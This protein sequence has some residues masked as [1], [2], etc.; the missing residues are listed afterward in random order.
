MKVLLTGGT[1][2]VGSHATKSLIRAG[3]E[4][5]LLVRD[6]KKI[7]R[8]FKPHGVRPSDY[9]KGDITDAD[10]VTSAIRG[11]D[12]VVHAAAVVATD[13]ASEARI[14]ETNFVGAK[15]VLDAAIAAGCDPIINISSSSALFP[16]TTDPVTTDHPVGTFDTAYGQT[17]AEVERYTRQLQDDG[18]PVTILY[19]AGVLGPHDP[20]MGEIMGGVKV[21]VTQALPVG[22]MTGGYVDVRDIAQ[23]VVAAMKPAQGPRRYLL[24]GHYVTH[25]ELAEVLGRA[26]GRSDIKTPKV[27]RFLMQGWGKAG[28]LA[29]KYGKDLVVTSEACD[30]LYNFKPAD[31]SATTNEL[32]ITFRPLVD[33]LGDT[34]L[35]LHETG[36]LPAKAVGK[37]AIT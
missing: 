23:A 8:V 24:W 25:E 34:V 16:F 6:P 28:D 7:D 27:P 4:V 15:N 30:Y 13:P 10:S 12:A 18:Q 35:W 21:W 31:Q 14:R 20:N 9:A 32:G 37:L 3:H 1:G 33:T 36:E 26:T 5:R 19:P 17:K 29:R 11:C 22:G 2:F